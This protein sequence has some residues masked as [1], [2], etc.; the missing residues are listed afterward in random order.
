MQGMLLVDKPAGWTSF[1]AVNYVRK[2]VATAEGK[3]PKQVKVGHTG[4]LDPFATGLL[5]LL[6]GKDYTRRAGEFSKL[7]K[8]YAVTLRLGEVSSTGDPEGKVTS[9][10]SKVPSLEE[11]QQTAPKF[12]GQIEQIPPAYSAI[13]VDGQRAYKL[14]RAG[15]TV[16]IEPRQVTINRLEVVEYKYPEVKMIA[17]VSSGTYIRTLVED[18]GQALGTGAYTTALSRTQIGSSLLENAHQLD[19]LSTTTLPPLLA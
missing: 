2:M 10:N 17:D 9:V 5:M 12:I 8:T 15:K 11:L 4:T 3:K 13:K 7:D 6:I 19:D 1:D 14:A 18:L 16:T